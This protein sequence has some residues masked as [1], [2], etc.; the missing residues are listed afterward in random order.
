MRI[1][2]IGV[3]SVSLYTKSFQCELA[4][5]EA[6]CTFDIDYAHGCA[7]APYFDGRQVSMH[8][9]FRAF[10]ARCRKMMCGRP[11]MCRDGDSEDVQ[12][13]RLG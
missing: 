2:I 6:R 13:R 7:Q 5:K 3:R 11:Y 9:R 8:G 12:R 10:G 4:M 1:R